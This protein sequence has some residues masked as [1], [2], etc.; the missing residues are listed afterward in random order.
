MKL[1]KKTRDKI[2]FFSPHI[3]K[4]YENTDLEF[5]NYLKDFI[6]F[7]FYYG[8]NSLKESG[9]NFYFLKKIDKKYKKLNPKPIVN[10]YQLKLLLK[11]FDTLIITSLLG[12]KELVDFAKKIGLKIIVIDKYK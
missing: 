10:F 1:I 2:I 3:K 11:K 5:A 8:S 4:G 12:V 9:F 6:S 7:D